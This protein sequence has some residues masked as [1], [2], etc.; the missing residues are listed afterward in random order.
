MSEIKTTSE[1]TSLQRGIHP[2]MANL[3]ALG[4][5]I[6]SCYFIGS[7]YLIAELGVSAAF[8]FMIGGLIIW[9]VMQSFAE[10]L[11]NIP[12]RG[13]FVSYSREFISPVWAVGTGWSYWFNWV[14]YV[15][16]EAVAGG[17]I[18]TSLFGEIPFLG[19]YTGAVWAFIFLAIITYINLSHVENFG[20]IESALA[21]LK[22]GAVAVFSIIALLLVL[23][24]F[25]GEAVGTTILFPSG[26]AN[27]GELFPAGVYPLF[28]YLAIIL[29]NFQGSEIVGLAAAE[30]RDPEK[31]VPK[32]CRQVTYRILGV[33]VIPIIFL[34]LILASTDSGLDGSMFA[35]ALDNYAASLGMPWLHWVAAAFAVVV[36]TAAFS[37]A[38]SGMFG[39]VRSMY[40][41]SLEGLAPKFFSKLNKNGVPKT[42]TIF[43]LICCWIALLINVFGTEDAYM[44]L[45]SISAFTGAICWIS[46]CLSQILFRK[47]VLSRG[48]T[49]K[50]IKNPA[51][52]APWLPLLI[53]VCLEAVGL[54]LMLGDPRVFFQGGSFADY[55]ASA[56][57]V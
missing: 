38:N 21:L 33:F 44:T 57:P 3:I 8:A 56:D 7:G 42:A 15:P 18:M 11:V 19:S 30:T 39:T 55:L 20:F 14:A 51:P 24:A 29:V 5:I 6:G 40:A 12:R 48:Y 2:W 1:T 31:T 22:I 23:G 10:L 25:G 47:K 43:T 53:G 4:G 34:V 41:L 52:L 54:L 50:D 26:K 16:S 46:I 32:A 27:W 37:C 13:S 45:L 35:A 9:V 28:G 17:I 36:L 49:I